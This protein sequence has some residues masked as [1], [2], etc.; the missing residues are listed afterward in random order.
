MMGRNSLLS[1]LSPEDQSLI[2]PSLEDVPLPQGMILEQSGLPVETIVFPLSGTISVTVSSAR[3]MQTIET[4]IVGSEGMSGTSTLLNAAVP[5]QNLYVQ[6]PGHALQISAAK[7]K[8][9]L[10]QSLGLQQHFL[11]FA[12]V[13]MTQTAHTAFASRYGTLEERLARWLLMCHD[14][15]HADKL[16]L[17][18]QA[19]SV[20]LA[21]RRPGVTV[22]TQVLEGKG[23]IRATRGE[24]QITDRD[25]LEAVA[26]DYYGSPESEYRAVFKAR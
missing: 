8:T 11:R 12:H 15:V 9:L 4:G 21:V 2:T 25:G 14:R 5:S 6:I 22:A 13:L 1:T 24:I 26:G 3:R 18:H 7:L 20:M 23:L 16:S 19:I 10:K 17:T